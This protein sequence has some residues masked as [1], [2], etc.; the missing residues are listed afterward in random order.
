MISTYILFI[1]LDKEDGS[2]E[3]WLDFVTTDVDH[4]VE[5][6]VQA[7]RNNPTAKIFSVTV[8]GTCSDRV[9]LYFS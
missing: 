4:L 5:K 3:L 2:Q 6:T 8:N 1:R 9:C 7:V